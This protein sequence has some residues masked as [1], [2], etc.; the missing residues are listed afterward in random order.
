MGLF[1]KPRSICKPCVVV[2]AL[3]VVDVGASVVFVVVGAS[4]VVV[5]GGALVVVVIVLVVVSYAAVAVVVV[6]IIAL[7]WQLPVEQ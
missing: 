7:Q 3:T 1:K 6:G 4:V 5:G 2:G